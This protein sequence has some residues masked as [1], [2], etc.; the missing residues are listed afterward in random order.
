M[1]S[2]NIINQV[3]KEVVSID[4]VI[5][6]LIDNKLHILLIKRDKEPFKD[7]WMLP[8]GAIKTSVDA[9]LEQG[10]NRVL[11]EKTGVTINY[12]EQLLSIGGDIDPRG[13]TVSISY[14][15]LVSE[16]ALNQNAKWVELNSLKDYYL[17][18][19]HHYEI[20]EKA[21]DRLTNKVN[22]STLPMHLLGE[23]FTLP[24][25]QKVYELL[26]GEKLDKSTFRKKIEET[27]LLKE[28]G[29]MLKEGAFRPA[30]L[31]SINKNEIYH[32]KRN[33]I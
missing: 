12:S 11:S 26:L 28:T 33:I 4:P 10:V 24:Q 18:F 20:I 17:G 19:K 6:S 8:G 13:W 14:I 32:F 22:Y 7:T 30:K 31:Y 29:E 3:D 2:Q 27:G 5:F 16:Q 21:V 25:L 23:N 1:Q 9:S 15:A